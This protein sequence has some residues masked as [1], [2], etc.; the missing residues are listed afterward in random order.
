LYSDAIP[1]KVWSPDDG[2]EPGCNNVSNDQHVAESAEDEATYFAGIRWPTVG[3]PN[4]Q[5]IHVRMSDGTLVK[6]VVETKS[7]PYFVAR[8]VQ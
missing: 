2:P 1:V 7:M 3:M 4:E 6:F 8:R 5:S